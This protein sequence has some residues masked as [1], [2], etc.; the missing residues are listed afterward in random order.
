MVLVIVD[1]KKYFVVRLLMLGFILFHVILIK[2]NN[3]LPHYALLNCVSLNVTYVY[4]RR[5]TSL[6]FRH[7][8]AI[9]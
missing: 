3:D 9:V 1:F 4:K 7:I 5:K 8:K 6:F 2:I